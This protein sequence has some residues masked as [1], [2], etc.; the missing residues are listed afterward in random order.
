MNAPDVLLLGA[1]GY[2]G[3]HLA[4]ELHRRG[5]RIRAVVRDSRRA[6]SPGAWGAPITKIGRASC[7]ERV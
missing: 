7:R 4:A 6:E 3:R 2:L 1:T 5:R